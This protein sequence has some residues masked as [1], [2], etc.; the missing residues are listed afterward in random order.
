MKHNSRYVTFRAQKRK[1]FSVLV[2]GLLILEKK[3]LIFDLKNLSPTRFEN[4]KNVQLKK[5]VG[6]YFFC[7][8]KA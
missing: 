6:G 8:Q 4:R 5:T 1:A 3:A 2:R 7:V